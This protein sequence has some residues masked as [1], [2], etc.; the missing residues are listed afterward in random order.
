[1]KRIKLLKKN[2]GLSAEEVATG[3]KV[4]KKKPKLYPIPALKYQRKS[5]FRY[6]KFGSLLVDNLSINPANYNTN[7]KK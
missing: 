7:M 3:K 1:M 5:S 6:K 4:T 2:S